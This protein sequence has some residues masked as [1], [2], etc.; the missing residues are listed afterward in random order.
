MV[1]FSE[2]GTRIDTKV[3]VDD[4]G[5]V[6]DCFHQDVVDQHPE[7]AMILEVSTT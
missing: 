4:S 6:V 3:I 7:V 5:Q 2:H 1:T